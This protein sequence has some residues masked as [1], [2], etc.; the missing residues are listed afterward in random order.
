M[1]PSE[2]PATQSVHELPGS[3]PGT[4]DQQPSTPVPKQYVRRSG[5]STAASSTISLSS[6]ARMSESSDDSFDEEEL[7]SPRPNSR[8]SSIAKHH[9]PTTN[10]TAETNHENENENES[11]TETK[12]RTRT[13][14][15]EIVLGPSASTYASKRRSD[16]QFSS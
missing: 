14:P 3:I 6:A 5:I 13:Q 7:V 11:E 15:G 12:Q 4:T 16:G 9:F 2:L 1:Q 10:E 8:P